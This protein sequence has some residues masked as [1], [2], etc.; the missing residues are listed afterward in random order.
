MKATTGA[1]HPVG[2]KGVSAPLAGFGASGGSWPESLLQ[3]ESTACKQAAEVTLHLIA[4]QSYQV[5][6]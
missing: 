3:Q 1:G 6:S 2:Q 5:K 4:S